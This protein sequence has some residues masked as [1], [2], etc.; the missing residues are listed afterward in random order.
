MRWAHVDGVE[1]SFFFWVGKKIYG[2][3]DFQKG[4]RY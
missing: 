4:N 1:I 2:E 3:S